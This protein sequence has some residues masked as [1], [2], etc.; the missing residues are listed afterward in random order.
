MKLIKHCV[1]SCL[2]FLSPACPVLKNPQNITMPLFYICS[3]REKTVGVGPGP[4]LLGRVHG[5]CCCTSVLGQDHKGSIA[6]LEKGLLSEGNNTSVFLPYGF[7]TLLYNVHYC[8]IITVIWI[9]SC[10]IRNRK[11]PSCELKG[12]NDV[13]LQSMCRN[14]VSTKRN[15]YSCSN[16]ES[17]ALAIVLM[18]LQMAEITYRINV[19]VFSSEVSFAKR[20]NVLY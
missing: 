11:H 20:G 9:R 7:S 10:Y 2:H 5:L 3:S 15:E 1:Y 6:F 4:S 12:W 18:S 16:G 8:V 17:M 13:A 19:L 14:Q